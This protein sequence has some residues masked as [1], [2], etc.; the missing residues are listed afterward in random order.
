[1]PDRAA[2]D[3]WI[4]RVLGVAVGSAD[5]DRDTTN[6]AAEAVAAYLATL[7]ADIAALGPSHPDAGGL[8]ANLD[9]ARALADARA[10]GEALSALDACATALAEAKR[11]ASTI[12]ARAS[13]PGGLVRARVQAIELAAAKWRVARVGAVDGL[14]ELTAML[15]AEEDRDLHEIAGIISKLSQD[16]PRQLDA[17]LEGLRQAAAVDD[18]GAAA[19]ARKTLATDAQT[20]AAFLRDSADPLRRCEQNPFGI[21]V[22]IVAP[23]VD[24]L[25][26]VNAVLKLG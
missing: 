23:L 17:A 6:E 7:P 26:A 18:I 8:R 13:V 19:A 15:L 25:T 21:G 9:R 3:E 24:A 2:C 16:I 4:L 20:A 10:Y 11:A 22:E 12:E 14:A 5:S 1:V